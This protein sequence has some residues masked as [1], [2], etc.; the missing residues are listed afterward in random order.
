MDAGYNTGF[1]TNGTQIDR[2]GTLIA[3]TAIASENDHLRQSFRRK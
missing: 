1:L 2:K 3:N